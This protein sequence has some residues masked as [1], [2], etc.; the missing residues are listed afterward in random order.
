MSNIKDFERDVRALAHVPIT[1]HHSRMDQRK[2]HAD[3]LLAAYR[4]EI[5]RREAA[6]KV[7]EAVRVALSTPRLFSFP[8]VA[9]L[10]AAVYPAYAAW[11]AVK[12]QKG[13]S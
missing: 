9:S 5:A 12:K 2:P 1:P 8:D 13:G 4:S 6:E 7:C 3:R 11:E 10:G